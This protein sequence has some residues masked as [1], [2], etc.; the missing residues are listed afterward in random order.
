MMVEQ[1]STDKKSSR[2]GETTRRARM[3]LPDYR[4]PARVCHGFL[5]LKV[6]VGTGEF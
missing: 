3:V 5:S 1:R 4:G 2:R 6:T